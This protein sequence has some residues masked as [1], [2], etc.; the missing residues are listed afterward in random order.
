[1]C[2]D[3]RGVSLRPRLGKLEYYRPD[4]AP[5]LRHSFTYR[6]QAVGLCSFGNLF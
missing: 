6:K 1:M 3:I 2:F 5:R 4:T